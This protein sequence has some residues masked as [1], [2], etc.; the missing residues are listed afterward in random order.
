MAK[1]S[2]KRRFP[3]IVLQSVSWYYLFMRIRQHVPNV[4]S[5][6][7]VAMSVALFAIPFDSPAFIV[8]YLAC[9]LTDAL[10]GYLARR[11][12]AV[13]ALGAR[14]DSAGDFVFFSMYVWV[15]VRMIGS[16]FADPVARVAVIICVALI[17]LVRLASVAVVWKRTG[18]PG[19]VHTYANK[20][21]GFCLFALLPALALVG[22]A[23]A[24][25]ALSVARAA[26][27]VT[28]SVCLASALEELLIAALVSPVDLDRKTLFSRGRARRE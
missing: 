10:D 6:A 19:S 5:L 12:N 11:L 7:R 2:K 8:C 13:T 22:A 23:K 20:G 1:Y 9:G 3:S 25:S 28:L 27:A 15:A 18:V 26:V 16:M 17:A 21:A 4:L 14:L 24:A